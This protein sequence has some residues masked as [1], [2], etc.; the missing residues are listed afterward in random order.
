MYKVITDVIPGD[1]ILEGG[2]TEVKKV[3]LFPGSCKTKVHINEKDCYEQ[4]SEVRVQDNNKK[5]A[6][7]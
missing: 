4:F 7:A 3:D 6:N 2:R 5:D 1:I